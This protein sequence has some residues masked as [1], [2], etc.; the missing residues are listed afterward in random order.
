MSY[1]TCPEMEIRIGVDEKMVLGQGKQRQSVRQ[2]V[3][4]APT[5]N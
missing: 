4:M 2:S 3:R 5:K 1:I